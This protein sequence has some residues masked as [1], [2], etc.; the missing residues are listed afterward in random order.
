MDALSLSLS[1][2]K[3]PGNQWIVSSI[4]RLGSV[5]DRRRSATDLMKKKQKNKWQT[6]PVPIRP[7]LSFC[8][9]RTREVAFGFGLIFLLAGIGRLFHWIFLF[10]LVIL[11]N[12]L[13]FSFFLFFSFCF[14]R[15]SRRLVGVLEHFVSIESTRLAQVLRA[16]NGV[17][18]VLLGFSGLDWIEHGFE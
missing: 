3:T 14:S 4:D 16:G 11:E 12:G 17:Y 18:W 8:V 7:S 10:F 9:D 6:R 13:F 15:W 5:N 2:S 1:N